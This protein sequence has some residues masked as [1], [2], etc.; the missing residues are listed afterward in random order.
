[1][2]YFVPGD[3]DNLASHDKPKD[4]CLTWSLNIRRLIMAYRVPMCLLTGQWMLN[5][6]LIL[7]EIEC[8]YEAFY[9]N[10]FSLLSSPSFLVT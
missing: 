8:K 10:I 2:L 1:M 4:R 3:P 9:L 7:R 5:Q 6:I